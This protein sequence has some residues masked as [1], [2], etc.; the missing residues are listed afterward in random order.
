[1]MNLSEYRK[2]S[3]ALADLLPWACLIGPGLVLNKDGAFMKAVAFRGPDLASSTNAQLVAT[4]ARLNNALRRL[5]SGWAFWIEARRRPTTDYPVSTFP[6]PITGMIDAE[7]R[8][9]FRGLSQE[10]YE[11]EYFI[12]FSYLPPEESISRAESLVIENAAGKDKVAAYLAEKVRFENTVNAVID[13]LGGF[14]PFVRPLDDAETLAYLH[15]CATNRIHPVA[16]PEVPMYLDA[17]LGAASLVGGLQP[18]LDGAHMRTI[19]VTNYPPHT[20]PGLL[21]ALN[22]LPIAYRWVTRFIP[23]DKQDAVNAITEIRKKWFSKRKGIGALIREALTKSES[24]LE[25]SDAVNKTA[26][27]DAALQVVGDD[28]T[29]FGYITPTI[30]VID[31]NPERLDG[32]IRAIMAVLDSQGLVSRV[33]DTNAVEAWLSSLPGHGYANCR[34]PPMATMNLCDLMPLSAIWAGP[35]RNEHLGGPA[36]MLTRTTGSTPFRLDL[37]Q[38]DVGHTAIVGPTGA[39]KSV[40][41][42]F[43]AMQFRRYAGAQVFIFDSGQ[44]ARITTALVGGQFYPL[45]ATGKDAIGFQ[46]LAEIDAEAE[47]TWALEWLVKIITAQ[48]VPVTPE[49]KAELWAALNITAARPARHRTLTFLRSAVQNTAVK[50]ALHPFTLEGPHGD[51]LDAD[52]ETIGAASW[53]DFEMLALYE[54][55]Q[56]AIGATL[57]YLFHRLSRRFDGRPTLI[58]IDEAWQALD[59]PI[60][61]EGLAD[62]LRTLRRSNVAVIFA[63]QALNDIAK[64]AISHVLIEQCP[65]RIF[66]P[67]DRAA[68]A[69]TKPVYE[70]F[71][72]NERQVAIISTAIPKRQY[73]YQSRGGNRLCELALT[74][75]AVTACGSSAKADLAA[76]AQLEADHGTRAAAVAFLETKGITEGDLADLSEL[77]TDGAAFAAAAE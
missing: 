13:I 44:S 64:S 62:W 65:T 21:D 61:A 17:V 45:G 71:G 9:A 25:D 73:Y 16:V 36:L 43:I 76:F 47:R 74:R 70:A 37:H 56:S 68:E 2:K 54:R 75:F 20:V 39:G 77:L 7:R 35:V 50:A 41:L 55:G 40:L 34:K 67:N 18:R 12:T 23:M 32:K 53:Q 10:A 27:A 46:P 5:G 3:A 31:D 72:L 60:F 58:I 42:N 11:S 69:T 48:G 8:E 29:S 63:T 19:A 22:E 28:I 49:I 57:D 1:M 59:N 15:A 14:M 26:N 66:L 6:D 51:L 24:V 52:G 38:G 4:R 33:E 30:T